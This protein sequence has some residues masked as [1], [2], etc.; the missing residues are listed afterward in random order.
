MIALRA[1]GTALLSCLLAQAGAQTPAPLP[2]L[3]LWDHGAVFT[4]ELDQD[5]HLLV[6]GLFT[7]ADEQ[8]RSNL[9]RLLLPA[10]EIDPDFSPAINGPVFSVLEQPD[11]RILIGGIFTQVNGSARSNLARLNADGSLDNSFN[12][13]ANEA[14]YVLSVDGPDH[15]I[16]GGSFSQLAGQ[17]RRGLARVALAD[18]QLDTTWNPDITGGGVFAFARNGSD[19]WIGGNFSQVGGSIS[20]GLARLNAD[21]T[22]LADYD[23]NGNVEGLSFDGSGRL[24]LCGRFTSIDDQPRGRLAR[25]DSLGALDSFSISVNQDIHDCRSSGSGVLVSGQFVAINGEALSGVARLS[26]SGAVDPDFRPLVGG[27]YNG[28]PDSDVL[29]WTVRELAGNRAFIGGVFRQINGETA[30]GAAVLDSNDG[31][32]DTVIPVERP[33]EVRTLVALPDGAT[34]IGGSFWRSGDQVRDN[35]ARL[36]ADGGLDPDWSLNVNGDV[37]SAG[38]LADGSVLIGGFFS[39]VDDQPRGNL[40]RIDAGPS[41]AADPDWTAAANGP[42]LVI[43]QDALDSDRAY[44]AGS[45]SQIITD[46]P[47][48]RGRMARLITSDGGTPDA[49][50]PAIDIPNPGFEAQVNDIL[51]LPASGKLYVAGVYTQAAGQNRL[52][53]AAFNTADGLPQFDGSFNANANNSVWVLQDAGD[54][55]SFYIG[56]EFTSLLGQTRTRLAKVGNGFAQWTPTTT[57]T[58]V[59]MALDGN[60]GLFV[61]GT[62]LNL[63]SVSRARLGRLDAGDGSLDTGFNPGLAPGLVW[64]LS[65]SPGR[66]LVAGSFLTAGAQSR[67]GLAGFE[68]PLPDLLF[69]DRFQQAS[70]PRTGEV[71]ADQDIAAADELRIECLAHVMRSGRDGRPAFLRSPGCQE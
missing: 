46:L 54:G 71:F 38:T 64:D 65:V 27:V 18:G 28:T 22:L 44:V 69:A 37:L 10:G 8:D 31:Q 1:I 45:F 49:F 51:Q 56:G 29:V 34:L 12:P 43:E 59:A 7:Q 35:L 16:I 4:T 15:L 70:G 25:L 33:A 26:D 60:G 32:V 2:D 21:G 9:F 6:A 53:L 5:G 61:G 23:V 66:L 68:L 58:P 52:G 19:F 42:V 20:R 24:L 14:V 30:I 55:E 67:V 3:D 17:T 63:N 57:G 48:A 62:F 40:A 47:H 11:G 13:G 39:R 36:L 41:P 50:N